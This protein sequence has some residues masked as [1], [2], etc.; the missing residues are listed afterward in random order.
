MK[1]THTASQLHDGI[2]KYIDANDDVVVVK[3][4]GQNWA[5]YGLSN[6][7]DKCLHDNL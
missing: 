7:L 5:K 1:T 2:K 6:N 3:V 4:D